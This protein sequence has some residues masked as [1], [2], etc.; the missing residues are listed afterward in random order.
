MQVGFKEWLEGS[1]SQLE[2]SEGQG[3]LEGDGWTYL[4]RDGCDFSAFYRTLT[5]VRAAA[6][7]PPKTSQHQSSRA[8]EPLII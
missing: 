7:L 2:G 1:E 3:Q 5:P 6:L 4:R 8:R